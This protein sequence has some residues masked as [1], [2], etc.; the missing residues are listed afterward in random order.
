MGFWFGE[1]V[2]CCGVMRGGE[3]FSSSRRP[4]FHFRCAMRRA[5]E[6]LIS[7]GREKR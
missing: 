4:D 2:M 5:M 3:T 1:A 6:I 7:K